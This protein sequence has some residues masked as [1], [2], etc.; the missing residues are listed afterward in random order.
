MCA[1]DED[2]ERVRLSIYT[3]DLFPPPATATITANTTINGKKLAFNPNSILTSHRFIPSHPPQL[4]TLSLGEVLKPPLPQPTPHVLDSM[5][6]MIPVS[7]AVNVV[8][9]DVVSGGLRLR[10]GGNGDREGLKK[11]EGELRGSVF[12]RLWS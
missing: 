5:A 12:G 8:V 7:D 2:Q 1:K 6:P 3:R 10:A 11:E 4:G 9:D